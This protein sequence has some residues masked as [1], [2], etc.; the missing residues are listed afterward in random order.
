MTTKA[1][2]L[3]RNPFEVTGGRV[4]SSEWLGVSVGWQGANDDKPRYISP[5][6]FYRAFGGD[7][8]YLDGWV[9]FLKPPTVIKNDDF[10]RKAVLSP[11]SVSRQYGRVAI[12]NS[13]PQTCGFCQGQMINVPWWDITNQVYMIS[14]QQ[15]AVPYTEG[16]KRQA[17]EGGL[18]VFERYNG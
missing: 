12:F 17:L 7:K 18:A 1:I 6:E 9:D 10:G 5:Q 16:Q 2:T 3:T 8:Q 14:P 15:T 4:F 11:E 13:A